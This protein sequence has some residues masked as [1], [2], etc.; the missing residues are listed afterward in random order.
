MDP[1]TDTEPDTR[2]AAELGDVLFA[3]VN[4]ARRLN[5][6]PELELRAASKRFRMRVEHAAG[7]A[8]EDGKDWTT[9]PLG[10]QDAFYDK[11]KEREA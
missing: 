7:L 10:E 2:I 1:P 5:V 6:D 4:V 11:A 8:A 9:L 3:L